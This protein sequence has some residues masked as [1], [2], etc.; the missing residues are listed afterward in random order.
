LNFSLELVATA[1][2][3]V[4]VIVREPAHFS[5]IFPFPCFQF[6][7]TR[8]QS[9]GALRVLVLLETRWRRAEPPGP[10]WRFVV[11]A[12]RILQRGGGT[13][14]TLDL[15]ARQRGGEGVLGLRQ[16]RHDY[17]VEQRRLGDRRVQ[18]ISAAVPAA[19]NMSSAM[20]RRCSRASS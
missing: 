5:L 2:D 15:D 9:I 4:E 18:S 19:R 13:R 14:Q 7:S 20:M 11:R 10:V 6:P 1:V 12:G 17:G 8:F 16:G 3:Y